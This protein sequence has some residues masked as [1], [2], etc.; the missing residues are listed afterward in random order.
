MFSNVK[1]HL[2]TLL[3]ASCAFVMSACQGLGFQTP[4]AVQE[5]YT[6]AESID[7]N[8]YATIGL[9]ASVVDQVAVSCANEEVPLTAC[10]SF[11]AGSARIS[12]AVALSA[13]LWGEA[14][15]YRDIVQDYRSKGDDV[16]LDLLETAASVFGRASSQW[17]ILKPK[18]EQVISSAKG[19]TEEVE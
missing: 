3:I 16:P 19:I 14:F 10:E 4:Q 7:E 2:G 9:Y 11:A 17:L 1:N 5:L 12:P 15:F 13:D 8:A 6:S 18:V